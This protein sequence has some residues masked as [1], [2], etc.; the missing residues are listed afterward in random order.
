LEHSFEQEFPYRS[1]YNFRRITTILAPQA[2]LPINAFK[3]ILA[4]ASKR[5]D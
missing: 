3:A 5:R 2:I 4:I 1:I